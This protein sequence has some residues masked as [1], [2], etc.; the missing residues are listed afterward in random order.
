MWC[1]VS[2]DKVVLTHGLGAE[3][4]LP[5]EPIWRFYLKYVIWSVDYI[6]FTAQNGFE[7]MIWKIWPGW[8]EFSLCWFH[9][10]S[11]ITYTY[12]ITWLNSICTKYLE[13]S[14]I[15]NLKI[16]KPVKSVGKYSGHKQYLKV[17]TIEMQLK[18]R[19]YHSLEFVSSQ[20][21]AQLRNSFKTSWFFFQASK[22]NT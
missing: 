16:H 3:N 8:S 2:K 6:I 7:C 18:E 5:T 20:E 12:M 17:H 15:C 21:R 9:H 11:C 10:A 22:N 13:E 4:H 14:W 1:S 19:P